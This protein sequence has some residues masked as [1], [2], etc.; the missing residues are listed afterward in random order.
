MQTVSQ[1]WKDNHKQTIVSEGFVEVSMEISD[2]EAVSDVSV[3]D[4]GTVFYANSGEIADGVNRSAASYATL[5]QNMWILDGSRKPIPETD[6]GDNGYIGTMLSNSDG[7]FNS[8]LRTAP[9][10]TLLFSKVHT[11]PL[12]AITIT[13][14]KTYGE[15]ATSFIVRALNGSNTVVA[16]KR[17]TDNTDMVSV[18]EMEITGYDRISIF[19]TG[20]SLPRHRARIEEVFIGLHKVFSKSDLFDYRHS[21]T[22]DPI[23]AALPKDEISFSVDNTDRRYDFDN[24]SGLSKYLIERQELSVR[25]GYKLDDGTKEWIPG[26]VFYLSEWDAPQNG[27]T[28]GFTAR[29]LLGFMSATYYDGV[30]APDGEDFY[31]LAIRLFRKAALPLR[32]DGT[33][34]WVIDESLK[35]IFTT[36]PLP[37]DTISNNLQLV[38]NA[39]GCVLYQDREGILHMEPINTEQTDYEISPF[40]SLKKPEITLSKPIKNVNTAVYQY[41]TGEDTELYNGT[42]SVSGTETITFTYSSAAHNISASV[43]GGEPVSAVYYA[44]SCTLTITAEGEVDVIITGAKLE[45]S[46]F[47]V[48][49]GYGTEGEVI[50]VDNP[51]ITDK[52]RAA[53]VGK[54]VGD[55]MSHRETL[56]F[57]WRSD[58]RLDVLDMVTNNGK[59]VRMTD[60]TYSYNGAFRATGEGRVM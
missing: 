38:A 17:V 58:P 4:S 22:A 3:T 50:T 13:W 25:Y 52:A 28:A 23:S 35:E 6:Y 15:Y 40:V 41:F 36:A 34:R 30:Y 2:P 42:V 11:N 9:R 5:E 45:S 51:L 59:T 10:I 37:V 16:E 33:E 29:D 32:S 7:S 21:R 53:A 19:V 54:N 44:N 56:T 60:V 18:V 49:V 46:V 57:D 26:G 31:T 48:S 8:F 12:P 27:I 43:T 24:E 55:Y 14:S 47:D 1:K 20:W 39:A